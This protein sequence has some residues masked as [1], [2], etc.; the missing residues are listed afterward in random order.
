MLVA[1]ICATE[2]RIGRIPLRNHVALHE[3]VPHVIRLSIEE[4]VA[5]VECKPGSLFALD[6]SEAFFTVAA[7]AACRV[8]K[9]LDKN[10][11]GEAL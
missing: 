8:L 2:G 3:A 7:W 11:S 4:G 9:G 10:G 6:P 1:W 5:E